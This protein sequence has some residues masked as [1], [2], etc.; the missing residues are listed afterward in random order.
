M[1]D[2]VRRHGRLSARMGQ[3]C[4]TRSALER[5]VVMGELVDKHGGLRRF[6]AFTLATIV[7]LE[8]LRF[9]RRFLTQDRQEADEKFYDPQG[10]QYDQ[11]TQAARSGRQSILEGSERSL[12]SKE[13]EVK[14]IHAA[15]ARLSELRSDYEL[16]ILDRGDLPWSAQSPESKRLAAV[17]LDQPTFSD[18][19]VLAT[20]KYA[21]EQR[22]KYALWLDSGDP[23]VVAN[24]MLIMIGRALNLLKIR[25]A[26]KESSEQ[27]RGTSEP[28]TATRV[29]ARDEPREPEPSPP[30][31]AATV[32]KTAPKPQ[33]ADSPKTPLCPLC[34]KGMRRRKSIKGDFWGCLGYPECNGTR[35]G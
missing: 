28:P 13:A 17:S 7:Q 35:P 24:A 25:T 16:I 20:A 5:S 31:P 3:F 6:H 18:D 8:T 12:T 10:S 9:C 23:I 2:R 22:Q 33:P 32:H 14:L 26:P 15:S 19:M 21:M 4:R 30:P 27:P 34:G 11:M 1:L 29:E